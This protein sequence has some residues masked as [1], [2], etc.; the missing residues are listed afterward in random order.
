VLVIEQGS[1][2]DRIDYN[3]D[4]TLQSLKT[5]EK[6]L[7]AAERAQK[8]QRALLCICLL[9]TTIIVLLAIL[10]WKWS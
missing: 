2:L 10:V 6:D 4:Q 9:V 3:I 1:M 5:G 8:S 7:K